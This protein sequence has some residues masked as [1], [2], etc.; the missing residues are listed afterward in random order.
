MPDLLAVT[1]TQVYRRIRAAIDALPLVDTHV[2]LHAPD[3]LAPDLAAVLYYHN[4]TPEILAAG[5]PPDLARNEDTPVLGRV[6]ALGKELHRSPSSTHAWMLREVLRVAYGIEGALPQ[7]D[8]EKAVA[9][10][11]SARKRPGR[12]RDICRM[13]GIHRILVHLPPKPLE[14]LGCDDDL[15]VP[16][17]DL[18]VSA[19]LTPKTLRDMEET[20]SASIT[21]PA[22]LRAAVVAHFK[23]GAAVGCRG[24]RVNLDPGSPF[25]RGTEGEAAAAFDRALSGAAGDPGPLN[26][27]LLDSAAVAAA[28]AGMAL[29]VFVNGPHW[30]GIQFPSAD[31]SLVARLMDYVAVHPRVNFEVY[32]HSA[33]LMQALCIAAKYQPNVNLGGAWWFGQFPELMRTMYSLRLEVLSPLKWT[34]FF[35]DARVAEWIIGKSALVRRELARVLAIKVLEGYLTEEETLPLARAVL[36]D[37]ACRLYRLEAAPEPMAAQPAAADGME[38]P[39]L[40]KLDDRGGVAVWEVDG[41]Y[42]RTH[43]DE[44]FTNFGQHYRFPFIPKD[45]LWLDREGDPDEQSF[46]VEHLLVERRLMAKGMPYEKAIVEAD[47]VERKYRRRAGDIARL[48]QRGRRLPEG[49]QAHKRLWKTLE[50]GVSVWIVDG[51]L[52]RSVF[53]IDFTAGGHDYVYEFVLE[54]EV[55]IDDDV[56]E[57]ERGFVLLHELHERNLMAKNWP[58]SKAHHDSSRIEYHCRQNPDELHDYL[59]EEGWA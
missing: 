22:E 29:Q 10:A 59:A 15:F 12:M 25:A 30:N 33:G 58:Y 57:D 27:F 3:P 2:H 45:E 56:E 37:N 17:S 31:E 13:A 24:A 50:N 39:Y 54:N 46:F 38:P 14:A 51:R 40:R 35:S 21:K 6:C 28:E 5:A 18:S 19:R 49:V 8:W 43:L 42:V 32:S 55:W 36:H 16:L 26:A 48:T 44:E 23:K 41:G 9:L 47:R 4:Y 53:D 52:V 7:V 11:A 34:G 20:T 1:Q